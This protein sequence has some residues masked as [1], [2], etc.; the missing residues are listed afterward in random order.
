MRNDLYVY[1]LYN[2]ATILSIKH[3]GYVD[4]KTVLPL[5]SPLCAD[6]YV[7]R[8]DASVPDVSAYELRLWVYERL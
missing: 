1:S 7:R 4:N 6:P 8:S 5:T 3:T 2:V